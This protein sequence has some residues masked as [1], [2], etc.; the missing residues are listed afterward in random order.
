MVKIVT[1]LVPG[2]EGERGPG[3]LV[4]LDENILGQP[5]F[6]IRMFGEELQKFCDKVGSMLDDAA[7][8][9][10]EPGRRRAQGP[11]RRLR[12]GGGRGGASLRTTRWSC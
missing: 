5:V 2:K 10:R 12:P 1:F 3:A 7:R 8:G 9:R 11:A 6:A 4:T